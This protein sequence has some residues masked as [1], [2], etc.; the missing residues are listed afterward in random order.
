MKKNLLIIEDDEKIRTML[1]L[2]FQD[3]YNIFEAEDGETGFAL[4]RTETIH[5][6]F[7]DIMLPGMDGFT[8]CRRLRENWDIPVVMLTARSQE[9]DKLLGYSYGADEYVTKPFNLKLLEARA[10]A[11]LRRASGQVSRASRKRIFGAFQF[12]LERG[13]ASLEGRPVALTRKEENLLAYLVENQGIT[14]TKQQILDAVWGMDY[15]GDPRTVDTTIRRLREK[16][17]PAGSLIL[18]RRGK[19]YGFQAQEEATGREG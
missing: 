12:D 3:T 7:L 6:I 1:G 16:M 15:E 5:L 18:T 8:V 9:E 19:G 13:E 11:L 4:L 14:L 2:Y 17:G 10:A